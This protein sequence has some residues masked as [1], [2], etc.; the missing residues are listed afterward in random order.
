MPNESTA[1]RLHSNHHRADMDEDQGA[2][3]A[4][5]AAEADKADEALRE[6]LTGSSI[7]RPGR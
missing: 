3:K 2:G 1:H 7:C 5:E 6:A 4:H